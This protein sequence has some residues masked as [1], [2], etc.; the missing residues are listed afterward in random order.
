MRLGRLAFIIFVLLVAA[1]CIIYRLVYFQTADKQFLDKQGDSRM[2]RT[3]TE[4]AYRG[5]IVDRNGYPLAISTPVDSIWA[6][7]KFIN[8]NNSKTY[9]VLNI[10]NL[11]QAEKKEKLE[12]IKSRLGRYG[13]IYLKRKVPPYLAEKIAEMEVPGIY[14]LR[15]Y[16]RYYPDGEVTAHVVGFTDIDNQ[17]VEGIELVYNQWLDGHSGQYEIWRDLKRNLVKTTKV[18]KDKHQG[19]DIALSI[20]RQMQYIAYR[21]LKKSIIE[22]QA[23]G[24]SVVI[25]DVHTGEVLAMVN[26]PSYNPNNLAK[27]EVAARRNRAITDVF[28]PGS[29]IKTFSVLAGVE[30]GDYTPD[31]I[32]DVSPGYYYL[33]KYA[34]RDFRNYG[35]LDLRHVMMKS[36][37][38]GISRMLFTLP[39][40]TL[41]TLLKRLGFG[42][43]SNVE[44]VGER[45]GYVPPDGEKLSDISLATLSFGYGMNSTALQLARAYAA[46]ANGGKLVQ[47]TYLRVDD[48][49]KV[50][51]IQVIKP[52]AAA[53]TLDMLTSVVESPGG[54]GSKARIDGYSIAGKTGT[55]RKP[56]AGGYATDAYMGMFVG[57]I[58]ADAPKYSIVVVIDDPKGESYGG[59]TAA[60]PVFSAIAKQILTVKAVMPTKLADN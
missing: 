50:E 3:V 14:L 37:N 2:V 36:S 27:S 29:T 5:K 25:L 57:V 16:Q 26:Q 24:G 12:K 59:G 58:P 51:A 17:G 34:V 4:H 22:N 60:A 48:P 20:D 47:P 19:G 41:P 52:D 32:I 9:Q 21:A 30:Y 8:L 15:E 1:F 39:R 28:E 46:V 23:K 11:S 56:I 38:V 45:S 33:N 43:K 35:E 31:D 10:L 13:F 42:Q 7:P 54:T 44:A 55:V 49:S 6:D 40:D 18:I 53:K